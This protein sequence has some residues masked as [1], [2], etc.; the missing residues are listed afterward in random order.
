MKIRFGVL[1]CLLWTTLVMAEGNP[2]VKDIFTADPSARV[3]GDRL[4]V[5]TSHDRKE[6]TTFDMVDWRLLST[7]DMKNWTE[8]PAPF[9]LKGFAWATDCAWAPDCVMSG[10]KYFLYLPV[11]RTKIGVAVG[12]RPEGPFKDA[13]GKPLI[14]N[15][16]MPKAGIEPID[17]AIL[18]DDDGQSYLYFGCRDAKVVKLDASM[19][20]LAGEIRDVVIVNAEGKALATATGGDNPVLPEGYAEAP[21][22]CRKREENII[23]RIRMDGRR[24]QRSCMRWE[25]IHWAHSLMR[26][27]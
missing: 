4:Y 1:A 23:L 27:K 8:H 20:K 9:T 24:S 11:D 25:T 10:G 19:T 18:Q 22:M 26:G 3:F 15:V 21:F 2:L 7:M 13:I 5:Y 6:A 12:D 17:P 14:D 16:V